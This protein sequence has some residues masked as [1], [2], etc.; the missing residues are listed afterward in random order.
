MKKQYILI[1]GI[2]LAFFLFYKNRKKTG[3]YAN[4]DTITCSTIYDEKNNSY[5][6]KEPS[7][8]KTV[9]KGEYIGVLHTTNLTD[10]GLMIVKNGN[11]FFSV[12]S[13]DF[14]FIKY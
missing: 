2:F 11:D 10:K 3:L 6:L 4:K 14:D 5:V 13:S 1:I 12:Y 9:K 8:C 7:I